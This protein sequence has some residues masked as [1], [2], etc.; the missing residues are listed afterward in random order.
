MSCCWMKLT[1]KAIKMLKLK[2]PINQARDMEIV[3]EVSNPL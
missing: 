3:K 2:Y 1:N